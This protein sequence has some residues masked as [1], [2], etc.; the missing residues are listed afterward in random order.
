MLE[1]K[2]IS[3]E[4]KRQVKLLQDISFRLSKG[5]ALGLTGESGAGKTTLI[6]S[7]MGILDRTCQLNKGRIVV[8][9]LDLKDLS[10]GK[11][12]EM[13][14]TTLGFIPQNPMTAFDKRMKIGKQ[15]EETFC[16]RLKLSREQALLLAEKKLADVNLTDKRR[17]LH[18]YPAQLSGGMLQR[19]TMAILLGLDPKYILA[20]EPTSALDEENRRL[21]LEQL[22]LLKKETGILMISH[23]VFALQSLCQEVM[24]MERGQITETGTMEKLLNAPQRQWTKEFSAAN[25]Q[26]DRRQWIWK[27]L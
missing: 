8:D 27:E 26:Q 19:V 25:R 24:V 21:L 5:K 15:M 22:K 18:S 9:G 17:V 3:V 2:N 10:S 4:T 7:V 16:V 14:G 23:D 12:R 13:C 11:R 1:V 20:D 6:K